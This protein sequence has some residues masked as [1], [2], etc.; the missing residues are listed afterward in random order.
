[1]ARQVAHDIKNPLTPIQ[2]SA[3]HLRRVHHD[4]G[5]PLSPVLDDCVDDDPLAGAAAAADLVRVLELRLLAGGQAGAGPDQRR[6]RPRCCEPYRA[7]AAGRGHHRDGARSRPAD[8]AARPH[9]ARPARSPTSSRTR[10]TR[11][12][13]DGR[14]TVIDDAPPI[15]AIAVEVTDTGVGM[16]DD[17]RGPDLRALLLDARRR[18]GPGAHD[19]QAQRRVER[20][21]DRRGQR[22]GRTARR[23]VVRLPVE[24]PPAGERQPVV[25]R[26][27]GAASTAVQAGG[28]TADVVDAAGV[29]VAASDPSATPAR[30]RPTAGTCRRAP[31]STSWGCV[32]SSAMSIANSDEH[33]VRPPHLQVDAS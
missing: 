11:C 27:G 20:R 29:S 32:T 1:M 2:L 15:T 31:R 30:R 5:E 8:R 3:E 26:P 19:R 13:Q 18:H 10:C 17:A 21:H 24:P 9:A 33:A 6:G 28:A 25:R 22:A 12:R 16:D 7:R 23:C 14:L 4:R